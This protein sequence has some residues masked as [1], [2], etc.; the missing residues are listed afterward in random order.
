MKWLYIIYFLS[1]IFSTNSDDIPRV[2]NRIPQHNVNYRII[3]FMNN[4]IINN[5][6]EYL[7]TSTHLKLKCWRDNELINV[8]IKINNYHQAIDKIYL[9]I[10]PYESAIV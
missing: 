7:E 2:W 6:F 8:D 1:I 3:D 4:N 5:C 10:E 9:Q